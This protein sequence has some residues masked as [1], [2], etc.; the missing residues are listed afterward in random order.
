MYS[1]RLSKA[2]YSACTIHMR[3]IG[4]YV[5]NNNKTSSTVRSFY[6]IQWHKLRLYLL[7]QQ[8]ATTYMKASNVALLYFSKIHLVYVL[9][10]I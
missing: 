3:S 1:N 7:D 5:L 9:C 2:A 10:F 4:K 8:I 6:R